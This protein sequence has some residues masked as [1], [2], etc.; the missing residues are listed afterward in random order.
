MLLGLDEHSRVFPHDGRVRELRATLGARLLEGF[1]HSSRKD[2]QWFEDRLTYCNARL[3]QGLLVAASRLADPELLQV[4]LSSL[5]WLIDQHVAADGTFAPVGTNGFH[6][7]NG[8]RATFDQ[9]PVEACA[10]VSAC[11][12]A[13]RVTGATRW[14]EHARWAFHWFLG[15]NLRQAQVYDARTGG[16]RDGIHSDRLNEN[17][18]AESTLSFL[19]ALSELRAADRVTVTAEPTA[20]ALSRTLHVVQPLTVSASS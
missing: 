3:S 11:L 18:G 2:W 12:E 19:M 5:D 7:H 10:M 17:Q 16:C 9:Q 6:E 13:H 4:A 20:I 15:Q 14:L 8:T 1:R